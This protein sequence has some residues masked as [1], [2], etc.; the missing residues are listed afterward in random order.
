MS[1]SPP[2]GQI[3]TFYSYKGGTGRSMALANFAWVLAMAGKRVL[4]IDWDLEAPGLHRYFHPFLSDPE[5]T[6]T[7]GVVDFVIRFIEEA[8]AR[9]TD[10]P[11]R[12]DWYLPYTRIAHYANSIDYAFPNGG[13]LD[14]IPAG[15]QGEAYAARVNSLNWRHFYEKLG[16]WSVIE[17]MRE[18]LR[19]EYD[20][21]LVDSRT[22]VSDTAG[23]CT[24]QMPDTV[25]VCFTLNFQS[26]DGASAAARS[27]I[28]Q[29][30][31]QQKPVRVLPV[32]MRVELSTEKVKYE[33]VSAYAMR[34]FLASPAQ[35]EALAGTD[36]LSYWNDVAVPYIAFYVFEEQLAWFMDRNRLTGVLASTLRLAKYAAGVD[37]LDLPVPSDREREEVIA[38]YTAVWKERLRKDREIDYSR[39]CLVLMPFGMK[40]VGDERGQ[41]R[42]VDLD[43]IYTS[44]FEPAIRATRL[45]EGG[46]LEPLRMD[47]EFFASSISQG[48]F[49]ALEYSRL[50][51]VDITALN[52]NVF[53]ELGVRQRAQ[54]ASTIIFYQLGSRVPFDINQ[55]KAYP[56][57]YED[58]DAVARS[59]AL[60]TRLL[61]ET[62]LQDRLDSPVQLA[63]R[64]AT[65]S[66]M[67]SGL[68]AA[69]NALRVGDRTRAIAEYRTALRLNPANAA[70]RL[71]L[72]L[73]L[74]DEG[75]WR[76]ALEQFD[77][78]VRA[79]PQ[80]AEA[81]REKGIA[82]NKLFSRTGGGTELPNG[83]ASLQRAIELNPGDFDA[84]ASLGGALKRAGRLDE[85]LAAYERATDVSH[86]QPYPLMNLLTLR[87]LRAGAVLLDERLRGMID[88]AERI[89]RAQV[90]SDPPYNSPWSFFDLAQLKLFTG[91]PSGALEYAERGTEY[92]HAAWELIT[93]SESLKQLA[94]RVSLPGLQETIAMLDER[95][96]HLDVRP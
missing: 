7:E 42:T 44:V 84:L 13:L 46:T 63:L 40:T 48:M 67:S 76:E 74:K 89:L 31:R 85:A 32:P 34:R 60:V 1:A 62:L 27:I 19:T 93:F 65:P 43:A 23:I 77:E 50:V 58:G 5:L 57:E 71:R 69:E 38:Q 55:V 73:V 17:H 3:I 51:L 21:I 33:Q 70:L 54:Q 87:A 14:F 28:D 12:D 47:Q 72:G 81:W 37:A 95:A 11:L 9:H 90:A 45:P 25:V 41:T 26:I 61:E 96:P 22:G 83:V 39:V 35:Q 64:A 4:A 79:A 24:V 20:V 88:R 75:A 59:R 68:L 49:E 56:Y 80:Y 6:S 86:G 15:K 8:S 10:E 94:D 91:D 30:A 52:P 66:L 2:L 29:R 92:A 78:A 53:Y 18:H 36:A 82:E 16:G